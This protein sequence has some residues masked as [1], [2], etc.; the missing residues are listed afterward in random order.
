M[1]EE[2]LATQQAAMRSM[3]N[4]NAVN[5][6]KGGDTYNQSSVHTNGEPNSDHSDLTAKHLAAASYA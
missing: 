1:E 6:S 2:R 5:N 4:I 3:Q